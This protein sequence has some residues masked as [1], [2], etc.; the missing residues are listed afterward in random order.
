MTS[1]VSLVCGHLLGEL[2]SLDQERGLWKSGWRLSLLL[3]EGDGYRGIIVTIM[4]KFTG[5]ETF[6]VP[7]RNVI[8]L[9]TKR[10]VQVV[11]TSMVEKG[12]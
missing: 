2:I 6:A 10:T 9:M 3:S 1:S 8:A 12:K 5:H 7:R 4:H 11:S